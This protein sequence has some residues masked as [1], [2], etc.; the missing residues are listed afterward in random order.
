MKKVFLLF[1][2]VFIFIS[3]QKDHQCKVYQE[4]NTKTKECDC[5]QSFPESERPVLKTDDYNS[6][7]AVRKHFTYSVRYIY[8][9]TYPFYSHEGDTLL[10]SG[11]MDHTPLDKRVYSIDSSWVQILLL[12]DS[13]SAAA[14]INY[15]GD[16]ESFIVSPVPM[17][18]GLDMDK[19]I[20][21]KG[22]LTFNF[23]DLCFG[24][25]CSPGDPWH[26][27]WNTCFAV[28]VLEIKN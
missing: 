8:P 10:L 17:L 28:K 27:C 25:L 15:D 7:Y 5:V 23:T 2:A 21:I 1:S 3:C 20:Y 6:W 13:L 9:E 18:K 22:L 14:N 16:Y 24:Y 12:D 4:Y 26:D 19:K 11:W